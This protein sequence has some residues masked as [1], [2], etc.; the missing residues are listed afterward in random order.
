MTLILRGII[1]GR[2]RR[3]GA[4]VIHPRG[5]A[6]VV[7]DN[8]SPQLPLHRPTCPLFAWLRAHPTSPLALP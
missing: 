6:V 1:G 7:N 5:A 2:F 3:A 8:G 4:E